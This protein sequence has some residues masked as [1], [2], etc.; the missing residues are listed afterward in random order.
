ME[1]VISN[2]DETC[3]ACGRGQEL[4]NKQGNK[5]FR[6]IVSSYR[7]RYIAESKP[8]RSDI[9]TKVYEKLMYDGMK[10]VEKN[11]NG[12][13]V[14]LGNSEGRNKV[15]HRFRDE[16]SP[17]KEKIKPVSKI[18]QHSAIQNTCDDPTSRN[19]FLSETVGE[20]EEQRSSPTWFSTW[21]VGNQLNRQNG[22]HTSTTSTPAP[23]GANQ[24]R[25]SRIFG[26]VD[27]LLRSV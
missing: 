20:S 18:I 9:I 1:P 19:P 17:R 16:I 13:W 22:L 12:D 5:K 10:F 11:D 7:E 2:L 14:V 23:S 4:Y 8:N 15:A 25:L 26:Q 3:I 6:D 27:E 21:G 24:S